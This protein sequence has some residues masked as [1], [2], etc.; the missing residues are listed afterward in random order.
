MTQQNPRVYFPHQQPSVGRRLLHMI[1]SGRKECRKNRN[2]ND[3]QARA[4]R[5][6]RKPLPKMSENTEFAQKQT[7]ERR[8]D[9]HRRSTAHRRGKNDRRRDHANPAESIRDDRMQQ[10]A[11][12]TQ[13]AARLK[14]AQN[15]PVPPNDPCR[16][17]DERRCE[18]S[19]IRPGVEKGARKPEQP[20]I[21][22]GQAVHLTES[23]GRL[24]DTKQKQHRQQESR[25]AAGRTE[26]PARRHKAWPPAT[27]HR[28][29][30]G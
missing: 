3:E 4:N 30:A 10:S 24:I 28:T 25:I 21:G 2:R 7:T 9:S 8:H 27:A 17:A 18:K 6:R 12:A 19:G 1:N 13:E 20:V 5:L 22:R 11:R 23:D 26:A 29:A 15:G 14:D 16:S